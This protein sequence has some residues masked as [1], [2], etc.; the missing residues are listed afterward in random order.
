MQMMGG[1]MQNGYGKDLSAK[2]DKDKS[3]NDNIT[4]YL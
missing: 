4:V 1:S 3:E 2:D